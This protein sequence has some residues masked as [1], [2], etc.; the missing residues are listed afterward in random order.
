MK[1]REKRE[2]R[3]RVRE[4]EEGL[5]KEMIDSSECNGSGMGNEIGIIFIIANIIMGRGPPI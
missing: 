2:R 5:M 3:E 1:E 4:R